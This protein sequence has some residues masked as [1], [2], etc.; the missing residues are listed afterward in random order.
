MGRWLPALLMTAS[1]VSAAEPVRVGLAEVD[2]TPPVGFPMAGYYHERLATGTK[3]PLKAKAVVFLGEQTSAAWVACDLTGIAT[4]LTR[5]V[6]EQAAKATGIPADNI[7]LTATH[8]HTAPDYSKSLYQHLTNTATTERTQYAGRLIDSI[9]QAVIQAKTTAGPVTFRSGSAEQK[10]P[11][12]FCRRSVMR[13]G[14]VRT[15]VGLKHPQAVR[16]AAPIDPKIGL[17]EIDTPYGKP[18]GVL[19]N[20]ALHLDT[21]GGLEWA[22]DYPYYMEQALRRS[23]KTDVISLFGTGT[24]GDINHVDPTGQPRLKTDFIGNSLGDTAARAL[25][26]LTSVEK[27]TLQV[28]RA[29]VPLPL[30]ELSSAEVQHAVQLCTAVSKGEK[31]DFLDHVAAYRN[32][33]LDNFRHRDPHPDAAAFLSWGLSRSWKNVGDMLPMEVHV[34]TLGSDVAIVTLPGEV[35]VELGLAIKQASPFRTTFVVELANAV[36]TAYIPTRLACVG[37]G[38]EVINSTVQPG[39]GELLVEAAIELLRESATAVETMK[40]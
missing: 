2:I 11:V 38:Y 17:I 6:R 35:F 21:V 32:L 12:S 22:G 13:D 31:I 28:R 27:P 34:I 33:M 3:D 29:V 16:L 18:L 40:P 7:I 36:E 25:G 39:S 24:C 9:A 37:G 5:A 26:S 14:S 30:K 20:F 10:T 23:L 15:W 19:S 1:V 8:S 4:D